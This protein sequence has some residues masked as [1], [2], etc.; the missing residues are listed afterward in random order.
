MEHVVLHRR[1][2]SYVPWPQP[3]RLPDGRLTVGIT[4]SSTNQHSAVGL[5]GGWTVLE[6]RDDG[7][8]W[9]SDG[10]PRR[11]PEL[12]RRHD[13]REGGPFRRRDARRQLP[14]A[15]ARSGG[16]YGRPSGCRDA[17]ER[18]GRYAKVGVTVDGEGKILVGGQKLFAQ[19]STDGGPDVEPPR[20]G[21]ARVS[22]TSCRSAAGRS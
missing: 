19:R 7:R 11:S 9:V 5:L 14:C 8:S 17:N 2:R 16:S 22:D 13:P 12:A 3:A 18:L 21:G 15:P 10:R 20:V 6:S 1:D 4:E